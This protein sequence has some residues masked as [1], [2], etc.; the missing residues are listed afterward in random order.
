[1]GPALIL[2]GTERTGAAVDGVVGWL[3]VD[4]ELVGDAVRELKW[5]GDLVRQVQ[6]SNPIQGFRMSPN[7][8]QRWTTSIS[9]ARNALASLGRAGHE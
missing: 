7:Q 2:P 3:K 9:T 4:L 6:A 8:E 1:M 5:V